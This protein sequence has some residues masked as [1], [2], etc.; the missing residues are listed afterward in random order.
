[1]TVPRAAVIEED[2]ETAVFVVDKELVATAT[3]VASKNAIGK[4]E[5]KVTSTAATERMVAHRKLVKIGYSDGDKVEIRGG[6]NEGA[7]VITVGRNAVR[8]GTAVQVLNGNAD[9]TKTS[10]A[11]AKIAGVKG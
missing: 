10:V 9:Q 4:T 2:G 1:L 7:Q 5:T 6:I 8:D 11:D 3:G